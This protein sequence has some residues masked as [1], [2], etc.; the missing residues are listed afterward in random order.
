MPRPRRA[1]CAAPRIAVLGL[2]ALLSAAATADS[3]GGDI[4]STGEAEV[5]GAAPGVQRY[6]VSASRCG[7]RLS[8]EWRRPDGVLVAKEEV[9]LV[10]GRWVRYR[11]QRPNIGQDLRAERRGTTVTLVDGARPG[12]AP[13][14][15]AG[16]VS[17]VAG[18][19]LVPF[20]QARFDELRAGRAVEFDY[21]VA[22]RSMILGFVARTRP[23]TGRLVVELEASSVLLRPFVPE[24]VLEF[25]A[26]GGLSKVTG[27]MLPVAGDARDP[28]PLDGV[29]RMLTTQSSCN[30]RSLS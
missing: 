29:L 8:T 24:T 23:A 26:D 13:T 19:E 10:E 9:E 3:L 1:P 18:P 6:S 11:L 17:L 15:L 30:T 27:R 4:H 16:R 22:E 25:A 21:L 28:T 14:R 12:R 2:A 20:L 7:E 5:R